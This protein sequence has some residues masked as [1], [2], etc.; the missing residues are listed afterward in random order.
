MATPSYQQIL[1]FDRVSKELKKAAIDEFMEY[2]Y[3]GMT[4]DEMIDAATTVAVKYSYY[5]CELGAQWYDLCSELAGIEADPAEYDDPDYDDIRDH[6]KNRLDASGANAKP[7]EV[8]N[9]FLQDIVNESIRVTGYSNLWRDYERGLAGGK[10]CRVPVGDTCAWCLMLASQGAWY[11]SEESAT[12]PD[13]GHYHDGCDCRAVFHA[14]SESIAGYENLERYKKIYYDAENL[15]SANRN[16][17][18]DYK[19]PEELSKRIAIAKDKHEKRYEAGKTDK[20]WT[21]YNETLI[22]MRYYNDLT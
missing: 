11:L 5:G 2:V 13:P 14:D 21:D 3:D 6:A 15:R 17:D 18:R 10:W 16:D 12:G 9:S 22:V 4:V 8:F 7:S 1:G 19:Y 20:Q